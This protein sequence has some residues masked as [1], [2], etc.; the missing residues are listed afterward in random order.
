[1]ASLDGL[2]GLWNRDTLDAEFQDSIAESEAAAAPLSFLMVDIDKFKS[3]NDRHGHPKGDEVLAEV[4]KRLKSVAQGKGKVY[5]YGGEEMAVLLAN[6]STEEAVAVAERI[7]HEVAASTIGGLSISVSIGVC[8]L[9]SLAATRDELLG[10][11][12]KALYDAK[13]RGR[14][15]VRVF[16]EVDP[17]T[18]ERKPAR[19]LPIPGGITDEEGAKIRSD[20]FTRRHARCPRDDAMLAIR[21]SNTVGST[22]AR[23]F[24]H[25]KMCGLTA[26]L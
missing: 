18:N 7:R 21:E 9:P 14:N 22:V 12:D 11:A 17:P 2:T 4:A 8:T 1:M 3:V 23:L 24:V 16:G 26:Q 20:Y 5:R 13:N 19:K 10:N 15:L 6:H 25:C